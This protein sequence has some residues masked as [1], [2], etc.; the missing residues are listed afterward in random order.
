MYP[1]EQDTEISGWM[2]WLAAGEGGR[3]GPHPGGRYSA[4]AF[5]ES[6]TAAELRSIVFDD[7][8]PGPGAGSGEGAANARWLAPADG[9]GTD[10]PDAGTNLIITE[11][12]R[13]VAILEVQATGPATEHPWRFRVTDSF[14]ITGRGTAV[15]GTL[16]GTIG[17]GFQ[18]AG[19]HTREH[20][21][22][23]VTVTLEFARKDGRDRPALLIRDVARDQVPPGALVRP[24][25]GP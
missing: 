9:P 8:P 2:R 12:P 5:P 24:R 15:F 21:A 14:T 3:E 1:V 19:L 4:T 16:S 13:P 7:V 10:G 11:G 22:I 17:H 6:G 18:P 25:I 20:A 23:P